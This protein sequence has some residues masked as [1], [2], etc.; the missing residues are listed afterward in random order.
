MRAK[1]YFRTNPSRFCFTIHSFSDSPWLFAVPYAIRRLLN[2]IKMEYGDMPI[3][4]T[5][6]GYEDNPVYDDYQR[7]FYYKSHL[8]EV[9]KGSISSIGTVQLLCYAMLRPVTCGDTKKFTKKHLQSTWKLSK[10]KTMLLKNSSPPELQYLLYDALS[11]IFFETISF[12]LRLWVIWTES[13][14]KFLRRGHDLKKYDLCN[15]LSFHLIV[16]LQCDVSYELRTVSVL[17]EL[18]RPLAFAWPLFCGREWH[19][20]EK[21]LLALFSS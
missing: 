5:E 19:H 21:L 9:L 6:N 1:I 16:I 18:R 8:N 2:Y 10:S 7:I 3:W 4:I 11:K 12:K 14:E 17:Q 20:K 13:T 15:M